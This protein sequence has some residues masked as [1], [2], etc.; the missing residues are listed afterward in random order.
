MSALPNDYLAEQ[1]VLGAMLLN[2]DCHAEVLSILGQSPS[3]FH[4]EAHAEIYKRMVELVGLGRCP[5]PS[6]FMSH[7][8][9]GGH[10]EK[11]GGASFIAHL[12][13][14]PPTSANAGF[15]ARTVRRMFELRE[16]V[17]TSK[18]VQEQALAP[19]ADPDVILSS[20]GK[21]VTRI[22]GDRDDE[23]LVCAIDDIES[24]VGDIVRL[25]ESGST[26]GLLTG[27]R[28]M[29]NILNGLQPG[30]LVVFGAR[31]GV[32]KSAFALNIA[33]NV[34]ENG[35][36]ALFFTMEMERS[37]NLH[38]MIYNTGGFSKRQVLGKFISKESLVQKLGKAASAK[39]LNHL[40]VDAST[41]N[42]PLTLRAKCM[43]FAARRPVSLIVVD[44]I[45]IVSPDDSR[46]NR[47]VQVAATSR[48]LK[49]LAG[50]MKC[51]VIALSQLNRDGGLKDRPN[52]HHLRES[53]AIEQD[54]NIVA[55]FWQ[56][57][58]ML[59]NASIEKNRNGT[60]GE[61]AVVFDKETQSFRDHAGGY[62]APKKQSGIDAAMAALAPAS[63]NTYREEDDEW[64]PY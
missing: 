58:Q 51:P 46:A 56:G 4:N 5:D 48:A 2:D 27:F 40:W 35:G 24:A 6:V 50:E 45:Q 16:I 9:H 55:M 43:K 54:A 20:M 13:S 19:G 12:T 29:D 42:T 23:G 3:V 31:P 26:G 15:Y 64:N 8:V 57:E 10:L 28:A 49:I 53:G 25:Y 1:S 11:C 33:A 36:N 14:V 7:V 52:L 62:T 39:Y 30:N 61:F 47:E 22:C 60:T 18:R 17:D 38:R 37:E 63:E 59:L 44:Y 41:R 21:E 34:A 32:G